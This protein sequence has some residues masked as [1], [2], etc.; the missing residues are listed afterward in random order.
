M[1]Q[2]L[3]LFKTCTRLNENLR[4]EITFDDI[5]GWC[6]CIKDRDSTNGQV[7]VFSEFDWNVEV[8]ISKTSMALKEWSYNNLTY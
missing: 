1:E 6:F 8:L 5:V 3:K 4:F 2:L 7:I